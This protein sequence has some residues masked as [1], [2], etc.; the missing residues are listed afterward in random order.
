MYCSWRKENWW[1][2][3][4]SNQI[5][6][7]TVSE[8]FSDGDIWPDASNT[9]TKLYWQNYQKY[10]KTNTIDTSYHIIS[11]IIS[12]PFSGFYPT[13]FTIFYRTC[14]STWHCT[15][16]ALDA[17]GRKGR[18]VQSRVEVT[19]TTQSQPESNATMELSRVFF[20]A[21]QWLYL[22]WLIMVNNG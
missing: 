3:G 8:P 2:Q 17:A 10:I 19:Q 15:S 16:C 22:Q 5:H 7:E 4:G 21:T 9:S 13:P 6:S 12:Y 11:Y 1:Y 18:Q 14:C 20:N